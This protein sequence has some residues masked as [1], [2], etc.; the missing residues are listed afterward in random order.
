MNIKFIN[1]KSCEATYGMAGKG[2]FAPLYMI[3]G[4]SKY[5]VRNHVEEINGNS[6][7]E[8][9]D[10]SRSREK[11]EEIKAQLLENDGKYLTIY[12]RYKNV[13]EFLDWIK[14]EGYTIEIHGELF[15]TP[16]EAD[17]IKQFTDF[18]GNIVQ[19]S[20]AFKYRIY[21]SDLLTKIQANVKDI[22]Q[23][24]HYKSNKGK[25]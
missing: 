25:T 4:A 18:S 7:P 9:L 22:P 15:L 21:D 8:Q 11:I 16:E 10:I 24:Y 3:K 6:D 20:S 19:Y 2:L 13:F 5:F 14:A 23:Y 17:G 12:G 1:G